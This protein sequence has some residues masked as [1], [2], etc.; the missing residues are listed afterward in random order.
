MADSTTKFGTWTIVQVTELKISS[1]VIDVNWKV[2]NHD[3][4]RVKGFVEVRTDSIGI[5]IPDRYWL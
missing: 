1:E 5:L 2:S 3:T 4:I